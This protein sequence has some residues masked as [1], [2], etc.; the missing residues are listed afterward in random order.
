MHCPRCQRVYEATTAFCPTDGA[1][2]I[3]DL[4]DDSPRSKQGR[5]L[6]GRYRLDRVIG[7]GAMARVYRGHDVETDAQVAIKVL[8]AKQGADP[9][10]R[11]RFFRE[12]S[13]AVR[14]DHPNV[15]KV[16]DVGR[17]EHDGR[18]Y[19]VI[20]LLHGEPLGDVM[21]REGHLS[22]ERA[23]PLFRDAAAGLAAAH[24]VGIVHRDVKP[25]NIFVTDEPGGGHGLKVVDFGL[26]KLHTHASEERD[27]TLGTAAYMPPEQV[28][29]EPV[30]AR[31]DVYALGVVMFRA[32]TGHLPFEGQKDVD[33]LAH[34]LFLAAPPP[35]WLAESTP[36]LDAVVVRAM[37]KRPENRYPDM[38][39]MLRDLERLVR[40]ETVDEA[41]MP[42]TP[43]LYAPKTDAGREAGRFFCRKLGIPVP[44]FLRELRR[45]SLSLRA[46]ARLNQ[47]PRCQERQDRKKSAGMAASPWRPWLLGGSSSAIE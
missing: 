16:L 42:V 45:R 11:E 40:G 20:E 41:P 46:A 19:M 10:A 37:R 36:S 31:S 7:H 26:A 32:I 9:R 23:Y 43:D 12:A 39:A 29:S 27:T 21:R 35:S 2:L 34:Q 18:P 4:E 17:R 47:P 3:A 25:D 1:R 6:S 8:S 44:D 5:L 15:I 38:T 14:I 30:D 28:L 13:A 24:A 33:L 22:V